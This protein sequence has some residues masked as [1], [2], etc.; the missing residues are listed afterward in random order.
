M[1]ELR[2]D[3]RRVGVNSKNSSGAA[4]AGVKNE[5]LGEPDVEIG[6]HA[7]AARVVPAAVDLHDRKSRVFLVGETSM[8]VIR[9]CRPRH[10][11]R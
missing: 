11:M 6:P 4:R 8:R 10:C 7:G 5:C 1:C 9:F 2:C 3:K